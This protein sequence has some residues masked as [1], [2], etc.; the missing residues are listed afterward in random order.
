MKWIEVGHMDDMHHDEEQ[1]G[2]LSREE[3][4][5]GLAQ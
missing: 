2:N 3:K 1:Q 5:E 4:W